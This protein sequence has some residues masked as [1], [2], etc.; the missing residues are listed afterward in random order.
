MLAWGGVIFLVSSR[1]I[2]V[3]YI[4]RVPH[5]DKA[6]HAAVYGV[7][8]VL[9]FR[10]FWPTRARPTP[11]WV[12][13]LGVVLTTAYG[14]AEEYHQMFVP[15][16]DFDVWDMAANGLGAAVAAALWEPLTTRYPKL[17]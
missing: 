15:T 3:D 10:A 16:R 9:T 17:R 13:L 4:P 7:L 1:P 6:M 11:V 5:L 8:A 12:L 2:P 14:A